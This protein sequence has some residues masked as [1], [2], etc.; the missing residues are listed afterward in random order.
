LDHHLLS[1]AQ[2]SGYAAFTLGV[3]SFLQK[4]DRRLK[5]AVALQ[6]LTYALHF[7]LLGSVTA[8]AS[9]L[10]TLCRAV[11]A[12]YTRARWVVALLLG[13]SL[14]LGLAFAHHPAAW[15]PIVASSIGTVAFFFLQGITMRFALLGATFLWLTNNLLLG[16]VG[17]TLLELIIAGVN[18]TTIWR[19]WRDQVKIAA[20]K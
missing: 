8:A 4:D 17:G 9:S 16:S 15:L 2:V 1:P 5:G 7:A 12:L 3:L 14:S 18:A 19:M 6:A 13:A 10:V 20:I 11:L